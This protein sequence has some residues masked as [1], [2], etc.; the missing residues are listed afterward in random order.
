[1]FTITNEKDMF[2]IDLI[3]KF[4]EE[5]N[6]VE[7]TKDNTK[8]VMLTYNANNKDRQNSKILLGEVLNK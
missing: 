5:D 1:M 6:L 7:D 2:P 8:A 4:T 3:M